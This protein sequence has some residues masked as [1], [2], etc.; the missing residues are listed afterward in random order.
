[1]CVTADTYVDEASVPLPETG[2]ERAHTVHVSSVYVVPCVSSPQGK[3]SAVV[4]LP[5]AAVGVS[6]GTAITLLRAAFPGIVRPFIK[7]HIDRE[8]LPSDQVL[9]LCLWPAVFLLIV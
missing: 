7:V 2:C 9:V 4:Q 6:V 3:L 8:A 1:M 5:F